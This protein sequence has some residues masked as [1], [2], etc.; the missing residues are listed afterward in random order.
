[1]SS[2]DTPSYDS[3]GELIMSMF[4]NTNVSALNAQRMMSNTNASMDVS[5]ARL[6]SGKR[7]NSAKDDAA[8]LQISDRLTSQINGLD[9]G[10]RNA[11]DG[12]SV[13]QTA[14]GSMDEITSMLQRIRTLAQQSAAGSNTTADR[15]ALQQ[16]VRQLGKEMKR[17]STDTT[18]V[19]TEAVGWYL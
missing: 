6:A 8:G 7:I 19:W 12:I 4:I 14:E 1:M 17:I 2:A 18:F 15:T 9:Q 16:E 11:N 3:S 5:Y 13:A 10:N